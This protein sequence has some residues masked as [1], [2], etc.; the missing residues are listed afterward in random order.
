MRK[1][2][3]ILTVLCFLTSLPLQAHGFESVGAKS[4]EQLRLYPVSDF[5][6]V[7]QYPQP[8]HPREAAYKK[9]RLEL[10][11]TSWGY[12]LPSEKPEKPTV[13]VTLNDIEAQRE[14]F[15][16]A[17]VLQRIIDKSVEK[18][19][20]KGLMGVYIMPHPADI[21]PE[22]GTDIREI[23]NNFLRFQVYT[24]SVDDIETLARG[25]RLEGE[26]PTNHPAHQWIRESSPIQP[27]EKQVRDVD[28][29]INQREV[30][31]YLAYLNRHPGRHVGM[32]VVQPN[33]GKATLQYK[34]TESKPWVAYGQLTNTGTDNTSPTQQRFGYIHNQFLGY[35][36]I[37][38]VDYTSAGFE[39]FY[40]LNASYD[41]PWAW[42]QSSRTRLKIDGGASGFTSTDVGLPGADFSGDTVTMG[43]QAKHTIF[44]RKDWFLDGYMGLNWTRIKVDNQLAGVTGNEPFLKPSAGFTL[45]REDRL[46]SSSG[47]V[48]L[49]TN[50]PDIAGTN[51]TGLTALGRATTDDDWWK[52]TGSFRHSFFLEPLIFGE[53]FFDPATPESSTL[54]H[55]IR[56]NGRGQYTFSD[57]RLIAQEKFVQGGLYSVRGYPQSV[58]SGDNGFM[59][60]FEYRFHL[61]RA[62]PV[63]PDATVK[64]FGDNFK[65]QP[66]QVYGFPD[67]DLV[68]KFFTDAGQVYNNDPVAGLEYDETLWSVGAGVELQLSRNLRFQ[69]DWGRVMSDLESGRAEKG[70]HELHLSLTLLY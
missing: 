66:N 53:D 13:M 54:A 35:D 16:S 15:L 43:M 34:V 5:L 37:L 45:E 12:T 18:L 57:T 8:D 44:Q 47:T 30:E 10:V 1:V 69:L 56:L 14:A 70:D 62:L 36:D 26:E 68:F 58:T 65:L 2:L 42:D 3:C 22:D 21:A 40:S 19:R 25:K 17:G 31:S 7:Y 59:G 6:F 20:E 64:L 41:M 52:L 55:E 63:N 49:A 24:A 28:D 51:P 48:N 50:L 23:G 11:R 4:P 60:S 67:W 38:S 9:I 27:L 33:G 32:S 61:P 39:D 46:H 29:L